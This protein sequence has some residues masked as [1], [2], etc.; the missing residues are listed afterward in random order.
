V[1]IDIDLQ[2]LDDEIQLDICDHGIGIPDDQ[3]DQ[4]FDRFV[5][6]SDYGYSGIGLSLVRELVN[7]YQGTIQV[8]DRIRGEPESGARFRITFPK[9]N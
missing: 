8:L 2:N 9:A 1:K 4:V 6:G 3:K 7:R 5:K